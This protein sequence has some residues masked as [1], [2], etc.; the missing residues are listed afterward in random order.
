MQNANCFLHHRSLLHPSQTCLPR[1]SKPQLITGG[2]DSVTCHPQA[3]ESADILV[4][5]S[6]VI[7]GGKQ[8][9]TW[10]HKIGCTQVLCQDLL[11]LP[12]G[13]DQG[14]GRDT[15]RDWALELNWTQGSLYPTLTSIMRVWISSESTVLHQQVSR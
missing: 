11:V 14:S 5:S 15:T 4:V 9:M 2:V 6:Y 1:Q 13:I 3:K 8:Q 12:I 10:A 7:V